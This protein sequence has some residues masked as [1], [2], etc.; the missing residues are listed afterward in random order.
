MAMVAAT[1]VSALRPGE[2]DPGRLARGLRMP[3]MGMRGAAAQVIEVLCATDRGDLRLARELL[4][5]CLTQ[6]GNLEQLDDPA[7]VAEI[8]FYVA[9]VTGD[10]GRAQYWLG[11]AEHLAKIRKFPLAGEF[12]YWKAVA[13]IRQGQGRKE[14][15]EEAWQQTM[16]LAKPR[17]SSGLYDFEYETLRQ[18]REGRWE[19]PQPEAE[20]AAS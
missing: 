20:A 15:A 13:I 11:R 18:V 12:D 10:M 4:E 6:M 17:P 5:E 9:F 19:L 3:G 16:N 8:A 2:L 14:D 1:T 7:M